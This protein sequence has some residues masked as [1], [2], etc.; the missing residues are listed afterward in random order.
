MN[1]LSYVCKREM[2]ENARAYVSNI[3]V[4]KNCRIACFKGVVKA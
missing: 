2:P 1:L 4:F 3:Q